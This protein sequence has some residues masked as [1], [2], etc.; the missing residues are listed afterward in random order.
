MQFNVVN[1]SS[2]C[3][4]FA[5]LSLLERAKF[6]HNFH[7]F[8]QVPFR[9][10]YIIHILN[11]K[12]LH[13]INAFEYVRKLFTY[14][15]KYV[16]FFS[17]ISRIY[18]IDSNYLNVLLE[19]IQVVEI[20]SKFSSRITSHDHIYNAKTPFKTPK[21]VIEHFF[22]LTKWGT[23]SAQF[24]SKISTGCLGES[25]N[26]SYGAASQTVT[27]RSTIIWLTSCFFQNFFGNFRQLRQQ[28]LCC[29]LIHSSIILLPSF[30]LHGLH[31]G[32]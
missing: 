15:L 7:Q 2:V 26:A 5:S 6:S 31:C 22:Y 21:S 18:I 28:L 19:F 29:L 4:N 14:L 25:C 30:L 17:D 8:V 23:Y 3:E 32:H 13:Y 1:G 27:F 11:E 20:V 16:C 10:L 24:E 12:H 9:T